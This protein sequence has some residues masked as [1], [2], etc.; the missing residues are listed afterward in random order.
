MTRELSP[1]VDLYW[2]P[3]GAGGHSV[4]LSGRMLKRWRRGSRGGAPATATT[5]ALEIRVPEGHFVIEQPP[6]RPGGGA[7]LLTPVEHQATGAPCVTL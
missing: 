2:L 3:L 6:L 7:H 1:G 5:S 4:R